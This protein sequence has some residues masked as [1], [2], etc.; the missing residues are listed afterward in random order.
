MGL[1]DVLD[2]ACVLDSADV[3]DSAGVSDWVGDWGLAT[4]VWV[5]LSDLADVL[6]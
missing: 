2:L 4:L 6:D 3:L 5:V 1:V